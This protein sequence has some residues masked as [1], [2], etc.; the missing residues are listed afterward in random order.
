MGGF[1][2]VQVQGEL[3]Q[4]EGWWGG[5]WWDSFFRAISGPVWDGGPLLPSRAGF[6]SFISSSFIPIPRTWFIILI[7]WTHWVNIFITIAPMD[8]GSLM[9]SS[10]SLMMINLFMGYKLSRDICN[11]C[12]YG[13]HNIRVCTPLLT[14]DTTVAHIGSLLATSSFEYE[15]NMNQVLIMMIAMWWHDM[16]IKLKKQHREHVISCL[17]FR[18]EKEMGL[19]IILPCHEYWLHHHATLPLVS[20]TYSC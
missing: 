15:P 10:S 20:F 16:L 7:P 4:E 12:V 3:S 14:Q 19:I 17:I 1:K 18:R 11:L 13:Y 5:G 6:R 8:L 2:S 9:I